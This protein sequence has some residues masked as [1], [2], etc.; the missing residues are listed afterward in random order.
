MK[1][2]ERKVSQYVAAQAI[3]RSQTY[4]WKIENG[5]QD[6]TTEERAAL[7]SFL[8]CRVSEIFPKV[9]A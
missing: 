7:A 4:Y 1:R 9:A 3:Q 2:A 6:A 5:L 8:G